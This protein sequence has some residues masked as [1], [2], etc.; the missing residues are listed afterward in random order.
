MPS[1]IATGKHIAELYIMKARFRE[2]FTFFLCFILGHELRVKSHSQLPGRSL[3]SPEQV[4]GGDK[5]N[6]ASARSEKQS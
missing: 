2:C 1:R 4:N 6:T 5:S 3:T